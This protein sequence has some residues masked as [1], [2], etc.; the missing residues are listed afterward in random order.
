MSVWVVVGGQFGSEGKGKV[1]ALVTLQEQIDVCIRCG[2]PN[3]GHSIVTSGGKTIAL[4][5]LPTGYVREQ[6]RL[7]IP[8]GGL[9]DLDV[10]RTEIEELQVNPARIGIDRSA[11]IIEELDRNR[12][13]DIA[14]SERLS[15][16]LAGVG[17]A[18][19]RRALRSSD[20]QLAADAAVNH[21]WLLPLLTDVSV[22]A[23]R[24]VNSGRKAPRA[25]DCPCITQADIR[26]QLRAIRTRPASSLRWD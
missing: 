26:R 6:A 24:A 19:A 13:R 8:A 16:T 22:E 9:I 5:Q 1:S 3:S 15:S 10:L 20:V 17:S 7:L 11:M 18:V 2:G 23:N 4:R 12:E 21:P 25:P 14:L